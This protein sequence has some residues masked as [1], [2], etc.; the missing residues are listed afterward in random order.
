MA[1][2][3]RY[4]KADSL[5]E[6][7]HM[8]NAFLAGVTEEARNVV[9]VITSFFDA[10]REQY[11]AVVQINAPHLRRFDDGEEARRQSR[12]DDVT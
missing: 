11:V 4:I 8:L 5:D 2:Q 9:E 6:L 12:P 1:I 10:D 3:V 7:E